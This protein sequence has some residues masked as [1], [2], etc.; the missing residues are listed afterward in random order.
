MFDD[1]RIGQF[2]LRLGFTAVLLGYLLVWLPQ[3]VVGLSL[4][5]LEMGEWIKF[6][7]EVQEGTIFPG[8]NAFYLPPITLSLILIMWT[9]R[10]PSNRWKTWAMRATAVLVALL[11]FPAI[12]SILG[13]PR[14]QWLL[15]LGL[16]TG[17]FALALLSPYFKRLPVKWQ[18]AGPLVIILL[19][20]LV[21]MLFPTWMF[22][23]LRPV[24][25]SL[26]RTEISFGIGAWLNLMGHLTIAVVVAYLLLGT[27]KRSPGNFQSSQ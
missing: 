3:P 8:R 1:Q 13:E 11:A 12:E 9:A 15:R 22:F 26:F 10:W 2:V 4:I 16:I 23:A 5:G 14:D 25:E 6:L 7:P 17:V 18:G 24:L 19:L 21:G 20:S 27:S